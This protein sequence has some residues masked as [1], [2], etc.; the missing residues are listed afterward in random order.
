M[1]DHSDTPLN[2]ELEALE[3]ELRAARPEAAPPELDRIRLKA[4]AR[5]PRRARALRAPRVAITGLLVGGM[6]LS[7]G[8]A[9]LAVSG[10]SSS[11]SA[12]KAAYVSPGTTTGTLPEPTV[13][14]TETDTVP[15]ETDTVEVQAA[16]QVGEGG[17][18]LPFSGLAAI[19]LLV[20]GVGMTSAGFVLHRRDRSRAPHDD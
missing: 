8:S 14:G 19:P 12:G 6:V 3:Q 13:A 16:R 10:I 20:L 4:Q 1:T 2:P 9:G 11:G 5:A 17:E 15:A 7:G 18:E